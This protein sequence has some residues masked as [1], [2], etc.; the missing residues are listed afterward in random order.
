MSSVECAKIHFFLDGITMNN[1]YRLVIPES[2]SRRYRSL[3]NYFSAVSMMHSPYTLQ[4]LNIQC[5][6]VENRRSSIELPMLLKVCV[7]LNPT[8]IVC[9][10]GRTSRSDR[11]SAYSRHGAD[12]YKRVREIARNEA[13]CRRYV[14]LECF[15]LHVHG[16]S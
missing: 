2:S 8:G 7:T 5:L 13:R 11:C 6:P 12:Q 10:V 14:G 16:E 1:G 15:E 4:H 3:S 9:S